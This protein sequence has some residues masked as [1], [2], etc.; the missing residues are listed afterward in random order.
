MARGK[1]S[2]WGLGT[3]IFG[4]FQR[5]YFMT[6]PGG[7]SPRLNLLL[8]SP[9]VPVVTVGVFCVIGFYSFLGVPLCPS[10]GFPSDVH[11]VSC[12]NWQWWKDDAACPA[13][14]VLRP[15]RAQ[16]PGREGGSSGTVSTAGRFCA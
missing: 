8:L 1:L 11:D 6:L 7:A 3:L 4:H 14:V 10:R 2:S 13:A 15:C 12:V 9:L 16:H 5:L